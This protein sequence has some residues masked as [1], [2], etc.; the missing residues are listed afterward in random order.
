MACSRHFITN[1]DQSLLHFTWKYK[2]ATTEILIR[3]F[4][5]EIKPATAY[6]RIYKL[7]QREYITPY[8]WNTSSHGT[9]G[10]LWGV[11]KKGFEVATE[12]FPY[13]IK[14]YYKP[15]SI[16]H[17]Y[18]VAA[19]HIGEWVKPLDGVSRI[20]EQELRANHCEFY[21]DLGIPQMDGRRPDGYFKINQPNTRSTIAIE[22][23]LNQNDSDIYAQ[24]AANYGHC[25]QIDKVLWL[26][27]YKGLAHKIQDEFQER[28]DDYPRKH[29]FITFKDFKKM[30]WQS[31]FILG[32]DQGKI[33]RELLGILPPTTTQPVL[34]SPYFNLSRSHRKLGTY[35][36]INL[37]MFS[38]FMGSD[39]YRSEY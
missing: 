22:V 37:N 29:N 3:G 6:G 14:K 1:R 25:D 2:L 11:T 4:F 24:I 12:D 7:W 21:P 16:A 33:V 34:P 18:L 9:A 23:E 32:P 20:S 15:V 27:A 28:L 5:P 38:G 31:P 17:D 26:V 36:D 10:T 8:W 19:F 39:S 35:S 13:E 30:G